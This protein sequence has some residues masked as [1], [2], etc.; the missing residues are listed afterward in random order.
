MLFFV[1]QYNIINYEKILIDIWWIVS[2][3]HNDFIAQ[4]Q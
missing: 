4:N 3:F 2:F 1:Q